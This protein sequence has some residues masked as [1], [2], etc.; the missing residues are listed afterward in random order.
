M[1]GKQVRNDNYYWYAKNLL[2][3]RQ[4]FANVHQAR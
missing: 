3:L 2:R 4:G 1:A